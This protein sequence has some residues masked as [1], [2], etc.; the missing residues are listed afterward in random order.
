VAYLG[1]P[2]TFTHQAAL[3]RFGSQVSYVSCEGI[4]DVFAEVEKA[5]LI[6]A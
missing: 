4:A 6:M 3:K 2:A 5:M 1:P